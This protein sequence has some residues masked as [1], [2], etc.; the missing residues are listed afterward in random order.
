MKFSKKLICL[1]CVILPSISFG[2]DFIGS[3]KPFTGVFLLGRLGG[4]MLSGDY[5]YAG[6]T[7]GKLS[8]SGYGASFGGGAGYMMLTDSKAW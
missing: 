8:V 2:F 1:S 5:Q 4:A 6:T 3:K 7:S